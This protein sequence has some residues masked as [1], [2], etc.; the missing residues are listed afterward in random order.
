MAYLFFTNIETA[1]AIRQ[2]Y[3]HLSIQEQNRMI[4]ANQVMW[5]APFVMQ[6]VYL[7]IIKY[8]NSLFIYLGLKYQ[9]LNI[10]IKEIY[11]VVLIAELVYVIRMFIIYFILIARNVS[12]LEAAMSYSPLSINSFITADNL[13][14]GVLK[15]LGSINVFFLLYVFVLSFL[16]SLLS[17]I[18]INKL[19]KIIAVFYGV[20]Y[21]VFTFIEVLF[22]SFM[23]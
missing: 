3:S 21:F 22:K 16:L 13:N 12:D 20:G 6:F 5:W 7:I 8:Y 11:K 1:D 14:E 10:N 23:S 4:R 19:I 18:K 15:L 2:T 17:D 9:K